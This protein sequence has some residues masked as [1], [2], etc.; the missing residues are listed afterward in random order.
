MSQE[1][2]IREMRRR[3]WR[4]APDGP[5]TF[6]P[7]C[8]CGRSDGGRGSGPC[9]ICCRKALAKLVG[10]Y[11]AR[12]YVEA[13]ERVRALEAEMFEQPEEDKG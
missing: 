12:S 7:C 9:M 6:G 13:V 11:L 8:D 5:A 2:D 1:A 3:V 4:N 10:G